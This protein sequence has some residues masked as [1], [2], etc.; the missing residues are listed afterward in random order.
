MTRIE[1]LQKAAETAEQRTLL[2]GV[3]GNL[4]TTPNLLRVLAHSPAALRSYLKQSSALRN[5]VLSPKLAEQ[6]AIAVSGANGCD[7]CAAAHS[8]FARRAGVS[9]EELDRNLHG[10]SG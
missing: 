5:G 8:S 7:Y 4:G 10:G 1:P 9:S 6:I 2:E 3:R